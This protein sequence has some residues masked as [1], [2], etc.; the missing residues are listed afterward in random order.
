MEETAKEETGKHAP[1]IV[2]A[3]EDASLTKVG[4]QKRICSI[5]T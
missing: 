3:R 5:A 1:S 2:W 4:W